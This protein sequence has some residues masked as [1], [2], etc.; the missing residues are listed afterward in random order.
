M[1]ETSITTQPENLPAPAINVASLQSK[2]ILTMKISA[3]AIFTQRAGREL[4]IVE[5]LR[6]ASS[7][8]HSSRGKAFYRWEH[9]FV[10]VVRRARSIPRTLLFTGP[11]PK[12]HVHLIALSAKGRV[13]PGGNKI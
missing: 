12:I 5:W 11:V 3:N 2:R 13:L 8:Q 4:Q 1:F 9:G 6:S 7:T 10:H